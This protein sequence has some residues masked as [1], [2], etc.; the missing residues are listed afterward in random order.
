[1]LGREVARTR[2]FLHVG[3]NDVVV[4]GAG[5]L[6]AGMYF[7]QFRFGG[8]LRTHPLVVVGD[9]GGAVG[10]VSS[11]VA[12]PSASPA[13]WPWPPRRSTA[14]RSVPRGSTPISPCRST[15]PYLTGGN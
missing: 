5:G 8:T 4:P 2:A 12:Q 15:W 10:V 13:R 7:V 9:G 11:V 3:I 14:S 1:M 6:A